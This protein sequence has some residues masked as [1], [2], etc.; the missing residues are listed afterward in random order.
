[1]NR[2][3]CW[4]R[5]RPSCKWGKIVMYIPQPTYMYPFPCTH[6][7]SHL[8]HA[9][10]ILPWQKHLMVLIAQHDHSNTISHLAKQ[11]LDCISQSKVPEHLFGFQVTSITCRCLEPAGLHCV[12]GTCDLVKEARHIGTHACYNRT[13][14]WMHGVRQDRHTKPEALLCISAEVTAATNRGHVYVLG[15]VCQT[16]CK[17]A[18][19]WKW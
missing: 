3:H 13:S 12:H 19:I 2:R 9:I 16:V 10:V 6:I 4:S 8:Y 11:L 5:W 18:H 14:G 15:A 17:H 7:T 1:M